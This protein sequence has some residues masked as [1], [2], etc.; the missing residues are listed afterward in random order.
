MIMDTIGPLT[1]APLETGPSHPSFSLSFDTFKLTGVEE[2]KSSPPHHHYH[3]TVDIRLVNPAARVKKEDQDEEGMEDDTL[4]TPVSTSADVSTF[5]CTDTTIS[6]PVPITD[7][8]DPD[9]CRNFRSCD[10]LLDSLRIPWNSAEAADPLNDRTEC[11]GTMFPGS[12][13]NS[14]VGRISYR[15]S[16]TTATTPVT[17]AC[18][19]SASG[20]GLSPSDWLHSPSSGSEKSLLTPLINIMA[21]STPTPPPPSTPPLHHHHQHHHHPYDEDTAQQQATF[22]SSG[23]P[24]HQEQQQQQQQ[25]ELLDQFAVVVS[26]QQFDPVSFAL[27]QQSPSYSTSTSSTSDLMGVVNPDDIVYHR[28]SPSSVSAGKYHWTTTSADFSLSPSI[29][30]P[31]MEPLPEEAGA[32]ASSCSSAEGTTTMLLTSVPSSASLAEYNQSTSKGHEIL[33]QAYQSSSVPL[34][35]LPVKP[36]KY[37]NRPSKT[38]LHERPYACPIDSCDRRF[39][40]SD[41]LT[42]HIRIHTGQKPFQCRICMRS[43]SRSDHLTTHIRTHTGEKPFTCETCGRKFARSDEKKRHAKVHLK[44]RSKRQQS[45]SQGQPPVTT[46]AVSPQQQQQQGGLLLLDIPPSTSLLAGPLATPVVTTT[47]ATA[48]RC[49]VALTDSSCKK[50]DLERF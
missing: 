26:Q 20:G 38:P 48:L 10:A 22:L 27:K 23:S 47:S 42:R 50:E 18:S 40:R 46:L 35:L 7:M 25:Q 4:N 41:E 36:R 33:S 16:F 28:S 32:V 11:V 6:D 15:G 17:S 31:K 30:V 43:F 44:Q 24:S 13:S 19:S 12:H 5:F 37:P 14:P 9:K 39:S 34:K 3:P 29:L 1:G 49:D 8:F 45:S 2:V 21:T